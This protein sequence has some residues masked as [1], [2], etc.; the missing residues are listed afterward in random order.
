MTIRNHRAR[1][2][3]TGTGSQTDGLLG[4]YP[5]DGSDQYPVLRDA[6]DKLKLNDAALVYEPE[7]SAP[8]ASA[9]AAASSAC[10]TWRSCRE[11]LERRVRPRPHLDGAERG[12]PGGHGGRHQHIVTNPSGVPHR[13][14]RRGLRAGRPSTI[15]TPASSSGRSRSCAR[16]AAAPAGHGLPVRGSGGDALHLPAGEIV[17]DFFDQLK[18][19]TRATP[20]WTTNPTASRARTS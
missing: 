6:L 18:S 9:S 5:I 13:Q 8:S 17:L 19:R 3:C 11:R 1:S 20:R 7:T 12:L 10:S 16:T 4:L 15:L 14:D 2:P